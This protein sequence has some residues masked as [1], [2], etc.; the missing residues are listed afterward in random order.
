MSTEENL[1]KSKQRVVV[2]FELAF[3]LVEFG[4]CAVELDLPILRPRIIL[5]KR[6]SAI[7]KCGTQGL[8]LGFLRLDLLTQHLI[9]GRQGLSRLVVLVERRRH[10]LHLRAKHPHL[11]V[12]IRNRPLKLPLTLQNQSSNQNSSQPYVLRLLN[13][14]GGEIIRGGRINDE[15]Q[16]GI[17]METS[18]ITEWTFVEEVP[19]PQDV[20]QLLVQGEQP[21]AAYKTFRDSAI[22][23]SKR[24]IVRD[25]QGLTGKKVE[26]YSIPY[27]SIN[28]WSTENA[29]RIDFN[30]EVELWTRAGHLKI[31]LGRQ[32]D[33][34]RIDQLIAA[35]ILNS[36][37]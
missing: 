21:Y 20:N 15:L 11:T 9:P 34:R 33:V 8:N 37:H 31:K 28:M 4:P 10:E 2:G 29:G 32:I 30:A 14:L 1:V 25:S 12:N 6:G 19:M 23:T 16:R 27:S 7:F 5:T 35:C 13:Y 24:L 36:T 22:F 17:I 26:I 3:E 18:S